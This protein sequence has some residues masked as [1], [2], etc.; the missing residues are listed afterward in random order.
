[1]RFAVTT[2][3]TILCLG[4]AQEVGFGN[5]DSYG[6][7]G[8]RTI[9]NTPTM[10]SGAD[11]FF[12]KDPMNSHDWVQPT[13]VLNT[14]KAELMMKNSAKVARL[15]AAIRPI[16]AALP[17]K[18][19]GQVS[20]GAARYA[21]HRY[22]SQRYGW[23]IKGLQPAGAFWSSGMKVTPDVQQINKYILPAHLEKL[24]MDMSMKTGF[25][26][27]AVVILAATIE[28]FVDAEILTTVYDIFTTFS[29]L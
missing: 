11:N 26:L 12:L 24:L 8:T 7:I 22:F 25:D 16:F 1:M 28:H 6:H 27:H 21:L 20:S 18:F 5:V 23:T 17:K 3:A 4:T 9:E 15:E 29:F 19:S 13:A 14:I 10:V 2:L